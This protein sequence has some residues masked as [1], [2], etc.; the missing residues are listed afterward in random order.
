MKTIEQMPHVTEAAARSLRRGGSPHLWAEIVDDI[1]SNRAQLFYV[2][3]D[4]YLVLQMQPDELL[5]LAASGH[6]SD[7]LMTICLQ[8]AENNGAKRVRFWTSKKGLPRLLKQFNPV[9]IRREYTVT[10]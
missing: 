3:N 7:M 8:I 9:E 4:S 2:C 6:D 5:I 1:E 10:V